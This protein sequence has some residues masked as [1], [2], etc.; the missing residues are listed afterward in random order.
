LILVS[1]HVLR[2]GRE[3]FEQV[4]LGGSHEALDPRMFLVPQMMLRVHL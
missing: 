4:Q 1:S 3:C 2:I